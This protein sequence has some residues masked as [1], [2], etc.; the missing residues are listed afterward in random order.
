M[1]NT[2]SSKEL[3]EWI[4]FNQISPIGDE[5]A[6]LRAAQICTMMGNAWR[7]KNSRAFKV[8]DFLPYHIK[9]I[10]KQS[11]SSILSFAKAMTESFKASKKKQKPKRWRGER[12]K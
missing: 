7:G 10:V 12:I 3:T 11:A 6:D 4:A 9:T 8:V 5:R 1:L 2:I